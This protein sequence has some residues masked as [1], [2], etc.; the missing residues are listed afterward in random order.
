MGTELAW[1]A[2]A[3][4]IGLVGAT[5]GVLGLGVIFAVLVLRGQSHLSQALEFVLRAQSGDA[6]EYA[7]R[8]LADARA[9]GRIRGAASPP[10]KKDEAV[11]ET[12]DAYVL[13]SQAIV[14]QMGPTP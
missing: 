1:L 12:A 2:G 4:V 3:V 7:G 8:A 9:A 13:N 5:V 14:D 6:T 11:D 10:G